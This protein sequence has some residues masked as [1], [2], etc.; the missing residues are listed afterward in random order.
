MQEPGRRSVTNF[1]FA[2]EPI[3]LWNS[4]LSLLPYVNAIPKSE[5]L[6]KS[7]TRALRSS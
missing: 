5:Q 4:P 7:I 6:A 1:H 2:Q 3:K